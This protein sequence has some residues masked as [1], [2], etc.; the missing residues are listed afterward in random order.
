M[1]AHLYIAKSV[2]TEGRMDLHRH[3]TFHCT[4]ARFTDRIRD[5]FSRS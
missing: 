2:L 1:L 4:L 3:A 5:V